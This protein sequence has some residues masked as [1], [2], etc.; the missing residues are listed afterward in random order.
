MTKFEDSI[1]GTWRWINE[2]DAPDRDTALEKVQLDILYH[3]N[4]FS[5]LKFTSE[6]VREV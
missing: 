5:D 4:N 6:N 1:E 2:V 3:L